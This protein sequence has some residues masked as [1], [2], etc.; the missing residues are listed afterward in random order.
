MRDQKHLRDRRICKTLFTTESV[1][2]YA[3]A[4]LA[5]GSGLCG[6]TAIQRIYL[7]EHD[8]AVCRE[9]TPGPKIAHGE[10]E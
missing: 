10:L 5:M 9:A 7:E 2:Y 6:T 4:N 8:D 1:F 3:A